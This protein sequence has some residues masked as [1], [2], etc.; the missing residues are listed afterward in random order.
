[1]TP[2]T[3]RR[4]L[5]T[6]GTAGVGALLSLSACTTRDLPSPL[7]SPQDSGGSIPRGSDPKEL[8]SRANT[9]ALTPQEAEGPYHLDLDSMRSEIREERPGV[10]LV[11]ALRVHD[12]PGCSPVPNA[13]VE[14]WHAD[15]GGVYSG[16]DTAKEERFLRGSQVTDADGIVQFVTVYPGWYKGRTAHIHFKVHLNSTTLLTSQLFFE[17]KVN[18]KVYANAPY[19]DH[20]G[21]DRL[22]NDDSLFDQQL[23]MTTVIDG[24]GYLAALNI[25]VNA[26]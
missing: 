20:I 14:I 19:A 1:M 16:F 9:C 22:N 24:D 15:A 26:P 17:E 4:A 12:V 7:A 5:I 2:F 8:L 13:V 10:R 25:G 21:R 6:G 11:V 18:T 23:V 3:R